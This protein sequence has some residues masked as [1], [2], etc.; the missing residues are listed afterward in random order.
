MQHSHN[1]S[2]LFIT[3]QNTNKNIFSE[4]FLYVSFTIYYFQKQE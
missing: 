3:S 1:N 4:L 2:F